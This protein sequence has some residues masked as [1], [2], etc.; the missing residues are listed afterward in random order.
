MNKTL[1]QNI[2]RKLLPALEHNQGFAGTYTRAGSN[3]AVT[4]I[5]TEPDWARE[6]E[7]KS[8]IEQWTELVFLMSAKCW[9]TTNFGLPQQGDR[10]TVTL[11]DG[12]QRHY[13][14]LAKR[15]T[16]PFDMDATGSHYRLRMK[17]IRS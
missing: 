5:P 2:R 8:V 1:S 13:A 9:A 15:K 12:V 11:A 6:D 7:A 17:W 14:L 3:R 4:V 10:L 16:Q